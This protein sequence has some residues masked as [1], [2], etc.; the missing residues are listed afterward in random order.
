VS[1]VDCD[2]ELGADWD[3]M[4]KKEAA[5]RVIANTTLM[6]RTKQLREQQKKVC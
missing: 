5:E 6:Q 2:M 3:R 1:S 4:V